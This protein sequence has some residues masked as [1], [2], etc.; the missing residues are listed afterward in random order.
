MSLKLEEVVCLILH[1]EMAFVIQK[2]P[3]VCGFVIA[4]H[5][6]KQTHSEGQCR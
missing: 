4:T 3:T 1:E 5:S 2:R 6:G